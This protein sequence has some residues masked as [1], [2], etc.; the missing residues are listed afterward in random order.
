MIK[1]DIRTNPSFLFCIVT[2]TDSEAS[3][4]DLSDVGSMDSDIEQEQ[5]KTYE[6]LGNQLVRN[7]QIVTVYF[8]GQLENGR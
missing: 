4:S 7:K 3:D 6:R 5:E 2:D 1:V 8:N